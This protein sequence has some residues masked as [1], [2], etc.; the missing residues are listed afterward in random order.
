MSGPKLQD[1]G[2]SAASLNNQLSLYDQG[3]RTIVL[4]SSYVGCPWGN[5]RI[6]DFETVDVAGRGR[7]A[8]G[9][10]VGVGGGEEGVDGAGLIGAGIRGDGQLDAAQ[11]VL[12]PYS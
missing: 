11:V 5:R 9:T 1:F 12:P 10:R 7:F 3:R 2:K 8:K 4:E 6:G